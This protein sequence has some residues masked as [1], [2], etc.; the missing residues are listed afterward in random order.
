MM[1]KGR[2]DLVQDGQRDLFV[3]MIVWEIVL[4]RYQGRTSLDR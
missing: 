4:R 3:A 2:K 1:E